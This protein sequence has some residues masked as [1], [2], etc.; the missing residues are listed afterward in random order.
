MSRHTMPY[1]GSTV[2]GIRQKTLAALGVAEGERAPAVC[3]GCGKASWIGRLVLH[4]AA[5][6]ETYGTPEA[7]ERGRAAFADG[8]VC[9]N[10][11]GPRCAAPGVVSAGGDWS[12]RGGIRSHVADCYAKAV[13]ILA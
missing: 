8:W 12:A 10:C 13:W 3:R 11:D 4:V 7:A 1:Q 6:P 5:D 2:Q 9:N